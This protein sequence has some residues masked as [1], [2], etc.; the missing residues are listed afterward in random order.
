M[1]I[2]INTNSDYFREIVLE[3]LKEVKKLAKDNKVEFQPSAKNNETFRILRRKYGITYEDFK[4]EILDKIQELEI[5]NYYQGP[6]ED[7]KTERDLIFWK[8]GME[9]F[10]IE[11]Y[12]K[13]DIREEDGKRIVLWSYHVPEHKI[14]YPLRGRRG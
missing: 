9:I 12:L 1:S 13:F 8:F 14:E 3:T 5:E 6:D 4:D 10:K 7:K 2:F 11:I